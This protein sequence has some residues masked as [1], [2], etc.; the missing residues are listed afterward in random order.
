MIGLMRP[1]SPD[2]A[3]AGRPNDRAELIRVAAL[4]LFAARGYSLTTMDEIGERA[5]IRGPSV[6]KHVR[7]KQDLLA[8]IMRHT[9]DALLEGQ[10]VALASS[11]DAETR[12]RRVAEAHVRYHARHAAEA[13]VGNREIG[14]L[15]QPHRDDVLDR[16]AAYERGLRQLIVEGVES[17]RF[18]PPSV[19]LASYAILDMGMGV[20]MW[21]RP[22]G[23]LSEDEVVY[24]YGEMALRIVGA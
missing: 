16:R 11:S 2:L 13:F 21:F 22:D 12:L 20:A 5:G 23:E 24:Q 19:R 18:R 6:Y 4:E 7:S 15:D 9:M 3:S 10:R 14:S 17:G 8:G 1:Y